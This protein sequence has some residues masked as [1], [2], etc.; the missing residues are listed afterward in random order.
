MAGSMLHLRSYI[1]FLMELS[2]V[3]DIVGNQIIMATVV[4]EVKLQL[5]RF[6]SPSL[7]HL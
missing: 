5:R 6:H 4:G 3:E 2:A 1:H 7:S